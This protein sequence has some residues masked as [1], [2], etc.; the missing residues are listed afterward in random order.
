[1]PAERVNP[2]S[3]YDSVT[4]GFSHAT[5]SEPGRLLHLSGQVAWDKDHN[6]VGDGD[7]QLQARQALANLKE[8]LASQGCTPADIVRLRTYVVDH[9][10]EKL[11]PVTGEL[12]AFY[13]DTVP[14]ANTWIGV[15]ALALPDFLVEIEA[16][17]IVP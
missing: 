5:T 7:L 12:M 14:A 6:L 1:M 16:T 3:L 11:G 9:T 4:Y 8:V 10:P 2:P 13:G 17:A 15:Q